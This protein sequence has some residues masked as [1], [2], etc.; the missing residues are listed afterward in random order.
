M[1]E[2]RQRKYFTASRIALIAI[3]TA[4]AFGVSML[5]FPIFPAA[6]FLKIDFSFAIMLIGGFMLGPVAAEVMIIVVQSLGLLFTSS[7]GVGQL[8]NFIMA[9]CFVFLPS[10]VYHFKKGIGVVI[11]SLVVS[12]LLQIIVALLS[13]RYFLFPMYGMGYDQFVALFWFILAF[14]AI[15]CAANSAITLLLYKRLKKLLN[16]FL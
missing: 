6:S 3:F 5:E 13:N 8:A 7:I 1:E 11:L 10:L 16:K 14:N 2:K 4:I 9:N 12:S 15:K